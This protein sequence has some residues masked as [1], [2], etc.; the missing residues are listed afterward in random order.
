[1][2]KHLTENSK[3][4]HD[5]HMALPEMSEEAAKAL[6]KQELDSHLACNSKKGYSRNHTQ[7]MKPFKLKALPGA[8]G[9]CHYAT[10]KPPKGLKIPDSAIS[11]S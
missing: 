9:V 10:K 5:F 6:D 8:D 3:R 4:C 7:N 11:G 1:M 2:I